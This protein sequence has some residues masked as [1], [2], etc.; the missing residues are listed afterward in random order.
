MIEISD[1]MGSKVMLMDKG[2]LAPG[3]HKITIDAGTMK[4]GIYFYTV[5][6]GEESVTRKMIVQ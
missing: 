1:I 3:A 5:K 4:A 2:M 6:V